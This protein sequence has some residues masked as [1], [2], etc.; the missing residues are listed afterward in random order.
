MVYYVYGYR[1]KSIGESESIL[2]ILLPQGFGTDICTYAETR[3]W[4]NIR[5]KREYGKV[6]Y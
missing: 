6:I 2:Y 1:K 4:Q 3:N 5:G